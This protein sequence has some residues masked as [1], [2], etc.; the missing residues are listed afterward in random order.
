MRTRG[1]SS[2]MESSTTDQSTTT[3][4]QIEVE[5]L[6]TG[7]KFL[8]ASRTGK[9]IRSELSVATGYPMSCIKLWDSDRGD[10]IADNYQFICHPYQPPHRII[11]TVD[12]K[13]K[14]LDDMCKCLIQ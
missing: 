12:N 1:S 8:V 14:A 2:T 10:P 9:T 7:E 13:Y 4:G 5:I 6:R 3:D 11:V